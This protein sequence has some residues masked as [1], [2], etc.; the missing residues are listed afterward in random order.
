MLALLAPIFGILGSI[1]PS[2]VRIWDRKVELDYEIKLLQVRLEFAR[3]QAKMDMVVEAIRTDAIEGQYLRQHDIS[4]DGG[5]FINSLRASIR[6]VI[7]YIFFAVFIIIK[8]AVVGILVDKG[9]SGTEIIRAVWDQD[10]M[11][12]FST[13]MGFWFGSRVFEK[14]QKYDVVDSIFGGPRGAAKITSTR[15]RQVPN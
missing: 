11:A 4:L 8:F 10:T 1:L 9:A 13:I 6:P 3:E 15:K 14:L 7:T 12:L 5:K 2:I